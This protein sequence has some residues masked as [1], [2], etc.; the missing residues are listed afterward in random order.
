MSKVM[1]EKSNYFKR[2]PPV[3]ESNLKLVSEVAL[4]ISVFRQQKF[5]DQQFLPDNKTKI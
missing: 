4:N 5:S 2:L 3:S 1:Q